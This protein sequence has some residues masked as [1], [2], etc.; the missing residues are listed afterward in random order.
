M[1]YDE[2]DIVVLLLLAGM[3]Y[4]VGDDKESMYIIDSGTGARPR[5]TG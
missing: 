5:R 1:T 4:F 3:M 2:R